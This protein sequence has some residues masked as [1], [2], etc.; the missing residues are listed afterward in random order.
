MTDTSNTYPLD[1]AAIVTEQI[2]DR[3][4]GIRPMARPPFLCDVAPL[5]FLIFLSRPSIVS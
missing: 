1:G 4:G 3:F 5:S 2:I